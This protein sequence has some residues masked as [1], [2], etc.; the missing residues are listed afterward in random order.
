M[1]YSQLHFEE[2][3]KYIRT[4]S[5]Q[6]VKEYIS[7]LN[8]SSNINKLLTFSKKAC[9]KEILNTLESINKLSNVNT[10]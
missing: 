6:G 4:L 1:N 2:I 5:F 9:Y 10:R 8:E 7:T 3:H